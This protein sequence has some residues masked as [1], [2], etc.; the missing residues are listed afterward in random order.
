M[1]TAS[2]NVTIDGNAI[3][4]TRTELMLLNALISRPGHFYNHSDLYR[5]V[6]NKEG[7]ASSRALDVSVS[8]LRKKLGKYAVHIVNRSGI[9]YGFIEK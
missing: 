1:D 2:R 8:R 9:G 5:I 7:N 3:A 4:L 6:W